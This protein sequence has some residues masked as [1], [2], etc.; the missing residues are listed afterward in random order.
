MVAR[1]A[2]R[3]AGSWI[4]KQKR[5]RSGFVPNRPSGPPGVQDLA[6]QRGGLS[7]T[8]RRGLN[9]AASIPTL[10]L[11]GRAFAAHN[12]RIR[13]P[14]RVA[15]QRESIPE[16]GRCRRRLQS[17]PWACRQLGE[18]YLDRLLDTR[19]L[20][21]GDLLGPVDDLDVR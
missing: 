10:P 8:W 13:H 12:V 2:G 11:K 21:G 6:L 3:V 14:C 1:T 17:R 19:I 20:A 9:I 18:Q 15:S 4:T 7:A 5:Y 16:P